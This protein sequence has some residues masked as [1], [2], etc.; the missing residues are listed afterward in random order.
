MAHVRM[1]IMLSAREAEALARWAAEELR[2]PR[3]QIRL[4]VRRALEQRLR[5]EK[6]RGESV[7]RAS[8]SEESRIYN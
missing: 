4:I 6:S 8:D 3:D 7:E 1:M 2:D 5:E